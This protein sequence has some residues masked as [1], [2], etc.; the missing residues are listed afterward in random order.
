M[1]TSAGVKIEP[2]L[3]EKTSKSM[4]QAQSLEMERLLWTFTYPRSFECKIVDEKH[5]LLCQKWSIWAIYGLL[6]TNGT[7]ENLV[8]L[9]NQNRL[10]TLFTLGAQTRVNCYVKYFLIS[11]HY[12]LSATIYFRRSTLESDTHT[13]CLSK[14]A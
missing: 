6:M 13:R 10:G 8:A 9:S 2:N 14:F 5:L 3:W 12:Y 1:R 11:R 7:T 4:K